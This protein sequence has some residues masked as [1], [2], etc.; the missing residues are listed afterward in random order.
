[1]NAIRTMVSLTTATLVSGQIGLIASLPADAGVEPTV[2]A[3]RHYTSG[4]A[5]RHQKTS[6]TL[7]AGAPIPDSPGFVSSEPASN[8]TTTGSTTAKPD[9][10]VSEASATAGDTEDQNY[11]TPLGDRRKLEGRVDP[12]LLMRLNVEERNEKNIFKLKLDVTNCSPQLIKQ[13]REVDHLRIVTVIEKDHTI[14]VEA[15]AIAVSKIVEIPEIKFI[16]R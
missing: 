7:P 6:P 14:V 9:A 3:E 16:S 12:A 11:A 8:A 15:P 10:K 13:L 2:L 1:M 5:E 4:E